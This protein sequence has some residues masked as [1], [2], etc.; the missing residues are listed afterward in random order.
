MSEGGEIDIEEATGKVVHRFIPELQRDRGLAYRPEHRDEA[1]LA[2]WLCRNLPEPFGT[3]S[4]KHAFVSGWL[5]QLLVHSNF[6]LAKANQAKFL[7]RNR[8]EQR[9]RELRIGAVKEAYQ[10]TLFDEGRES[11]ATVDGTCKFEFHPQAYAPV[12]DYDG[13]F[14]VFAFSGHYYG[15]IGDFDSRE[16]FECAVWL[17][18]QT[19]VGRIKL[20]ARD[21]VRREGCS[22][23]RQKADGR[24]YPDF[25]CQ[26]DAGVVL[27]IENKGADRWMAAA[28][29]RVIG[30]LWAELS[31]GRCRFV[32]VKDRRWDWIDERLR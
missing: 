20:L 23:F 1:K 28:D 24:F 15:R 17:D 10:K 19:Q 29:D 9:I 22:F 16:E 25:L 4:S 21:L 30:E 32:M 12:R 31:D 2:V 13:R 27:A 5:K 8:I 26:L 11:R 18:Q 14:G 3:H 7:V 6:D